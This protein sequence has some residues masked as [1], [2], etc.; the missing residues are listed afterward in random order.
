VSCIA[1]HGTSARVWY[2]LPVYLEAVTVSVHYADYLRHTV[3]NAR[4]FDRWI[5]VTVPEDTETISLC[6][7]EGIE[8]II[9]HRLHQDG[10]AFAKGKAINDGLDALTKRDWLL[11]LDSDVLLPEDFRQALEH[12]N[13][14]TQCLYGI[15]QRA[16]ARTPADLCKDPAHLSVIH[17]SLPCL[18]FFQLFHASCAHRYPEASTNASFDDA[19]FRALWPAARRRLLPMRCVHLGENRTNWLG[20][21][22]PRFGSRAHVSWAWIRPLIRCRSFL[23]MFIGILCWPIYRWRGNTAVSCDKQQ[24]C[25]ATRRG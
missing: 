3:R 14:D 21:R 18:G 24:K 6:S 4:H 9:T 22:N 17:E 11:V 7:K 10:A 13:P 19:L 25:F 20:R 2:T 8:C 23:Y 5:I 16:L 12:A 1:L 15:A